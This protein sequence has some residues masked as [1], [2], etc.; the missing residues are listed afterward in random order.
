MILLI[1]YFW[2]AGL[3]VKR[4]IDMMPVWELVQKK[5]KYINQKMIR[6]NT[7]VT[8]KEIQDWIIQNKPVFTLEELRAIR[9]WEESH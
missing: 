2:G 1:L 5:W 4:G 8:N 7:F 6:K 9:V 3:Q